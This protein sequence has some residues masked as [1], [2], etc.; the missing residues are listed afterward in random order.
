V[1]ALPKG[2]TKNCLGEIND[3]AEA[4]FFDLSLALFN[5]PGNGI[6]ISLDIGIKNT[7]L[8]QVM[9]RIVHHHCMDGQD[10]SA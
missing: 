9:L 1:V 3:K 5:N 6:G 8:H 10:S 4:S 7:E 2:K